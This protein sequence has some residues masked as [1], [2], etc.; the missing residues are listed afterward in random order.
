MSVANTHIVV[1]YQAGS[2]M[3]AETDRHITSQNDNSAHAALPQQLPVAYSVL[4]SFGKIRSI[5][6][7]GA[8]LLGWSAEALIGRT[9]SDLSSS[10]SDKERTRETLIWKQ[11]NN[12]E[13]GENDLEVLRPDGQLIWIR[14]TLHPIYTS[15]HHIQGFYAC[16]LDIT[17]LQAEHDR[18]RG[19]TDHIEH[20]LI[21]RTQSLMEIIE[22][23]RQQNRHYIQ[24]CHD[25]VHEIRTPLTNMILRLH[26][27]EHGSDLDRAQHQAVLRQQIKYLGQLIDDI[28]VFAKTQTGDK[29]Q[30]TT[31]D[32]HQLIADVVMA[33]L[34]H[35]ERKG[36]DLVT[37]FTDEPFQIRGNAIQ[38]AQVCSNLVANAL[39]YTSAGT[40]KIMT[41]LDIGSKQVKISVID[42]GIGISDEDMPLI[43]ERF[44]RGRNVLQADIPGTG[45]GLGIVREIVKA[46]NGQIG[47]RSQ[48]GS[49]TTFVVLLPLV[50]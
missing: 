19:L 18:F 34:P 22:K 13:Y 27:L 29:S 36:L 2:I 28:S 5:T 31:V 23:V 16:F 40:I 3:N 17:E 20:H 1:L 42:T 21:E 26:L 47:V 14:V 46:H 44:Y 12:E 38:L 50:V 43:F 45:L 4:D 24:F 48:Q 8:K 7:Y 41:E 15:S 10:A 9:L 35:T 32:L 30:F 11:S 39:N 25:M 37:V 6:N 49:G 33:H